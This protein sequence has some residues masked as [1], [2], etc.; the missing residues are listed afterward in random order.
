MKK[1]QEKCCNLNEVISIFHNGIS[2]YIY[3]KVNKND[4]E[5]LIQDVILKI[6]NSYTENKSVKNLKSWLYS[7]TNNTIADYYRKKYKEVENISSEILQDNIEKKLS[8]DDFIIPMIHLLDEKYS[9]ILLMNDIEQLS[10]K[11]IAQKTDLS[12]SA[13]KSRVLRARKMLRDL[14]LE[15]CIMEFD[16]NKNIVSCEIKPSC[17]PLKEIENQIIDKKIK[18]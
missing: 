9:Q 18:K 11:E 16:K 3:I 6:V 13:V 4:A 8:A 7:V 17:T 12:I 10:Q 1:T 15:C 5:D 14:F 2:K